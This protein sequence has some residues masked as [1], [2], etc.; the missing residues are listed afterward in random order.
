MLRETF[1]WG[2]KCLSS[3]LEQVWL[4]F[5]LWCLFAYGQIDI[6]H[7]STKVKFSQA[8]VCPPEDTPG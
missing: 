6:Y 1:E 5:A 7:P 2:E 8:C 4:I 3:Q